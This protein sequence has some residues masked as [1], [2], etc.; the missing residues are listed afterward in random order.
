VT[1]D[2]TPKFLAHDPID[3]MH[4]LTIKDPHNPA[5]MVTLPL[6]LRGVTS[7]INVR[8]PTLDKWNSDAFM[9]LSLTSDSL[10]W[11]PN[12]THYSDQ[13]AAMT[14]YSGNVVS[15]A[16]AR[17]HVGILAINSLSSLTTDLIDVTDDENVHQVL[18]LKVMIL[19]VETSLNGHIRSRNIASI[20]LQTLVARWMISPDHAKRTVVMTT[21]RGV[22]TCLNPTLSRCFPTN[23]RMLRYKR[24]PH[25]MFTDTMFA[26]TVFR[27]G[28]KMAQIYS[29][30]FG[31][32]RAHSMKHKG[33]AHDTLS[34]MFHRDGVPL[35]MVTDGSKVQTQG[36]FR[37]KLREA[38]CHLRVTEPYSPWEQ[39]AEGCIREIK[40]GSSRKMIRTGSPKPYGTTALSSKLLCILA[41]AMTFI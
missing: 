31:W 12:T 17:R 40:R 24:L 6:A 11:D 4:G 25:I 20:D 36:D 8:A 9:R 29:T 28:N 34:L 16:A 33:K 2:E 27:Q 23:D 35:T 32:A 13:E 18:T 5:Q 15:C 30:S 10:T 37:Q 26:S 22:R 1:V 19:S 41:R 3:H 14:D 21:Q 39:A 38:D 7:L